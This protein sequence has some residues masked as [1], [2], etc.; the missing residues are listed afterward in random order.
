MYTVRRGFSRWRPAVVAAAATLATTVALVP[1]A[2]HPND[3]GHAV[4]AYYYV[5]YDE[6][7]FAKALFQP[8]QP[9]NSDNLSVIQRHVDQA[10]SAGIDGFIVDWYGDGDRTDANFGH[11]LDVAEKSNF[12]AT[13]H[14]ETPY[15]WGVDDVVAQLAAFYAHHANRPSIVRYQGRPVILFWRASTFDN[16]TWS[17]IR[18]RVDP[19]HRAVWL[20]DGDSFSVLAGD[21]WDG[22]SPYAI[23]WSNNPTL[24]LQR[25]A[26]SARSVA[27]DKLWNPVVSPGCNDS[28]ARAPTCVQDRAGGSY[29]Q[30]T[31]DGALASNPDW[32]VVVSTFNEWMESTQIEPSVQWGDQYLQLTKQN[33]AQFKGA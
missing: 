22:I 24:Q 4:L 6:D 7:S 14:F 32:A 10:K 33:A 16:A 29:Y 31:W 1:S 17:S 9:Y 18:Q 20:A 30:A 21:A 28:A 27:P 26:S 13:I 15:F 12:S 19:D 23:A 11:L 8:L 3:L 5:W 25:W 2:A